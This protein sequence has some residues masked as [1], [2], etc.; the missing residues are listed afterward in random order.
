M[1]VAVARRVRGE[2]PAQRRDVA[3]GEVDDVDVVAHAG[4]VGRRVVVAEHAQPLAAPDRHLRDEGHQVV[5]DADADPRR[6]ARSRA[7]RP[8]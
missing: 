4:A 8:G 1:T 5:R 6:S 2:D 3:G 7:R